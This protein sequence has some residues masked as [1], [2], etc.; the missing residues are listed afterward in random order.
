MNIAYFSPIFW[1]SLKQ[2]PQH[3][4]EELAKLEG[5]SI[6]F[7]EPSIS[8]ITSLIKGTNDFRSKSEKK[9]DSLYI[10]R[11][12]GGF[13]FPKSFENFDFLD[14]NTLYEKKQLRKLLNESDIIILGSPIY[15]KNIRKQNNKKVV[16]DKMDDY[17][18][19]TEN[20]LLKILIRSSEELLFSRAD[21]IICTSEALS[22]KMKT[23]KNVKL[24]RNAAEEN[25]YQ[26]SLKES[27]VSKSIFNNKQNK[28]IFGYVGTVDH[29]FDYSAVKTIL[30]SNPLFNI[31][32]VGSDNIPQSKINDARVIYYSPVPKED[33]GSIINSF[34]YCLYP[35]K[36]DENLD[37]INPVKIYEYL[38]LNKKIIAIHSRET[39]LIRG[40]TLYK[41]IE[42]L[43]EILINL[44]QIKQPFETLEEQKEFTVNNN[45]NNRAKAVQ[46]LLEKLVGCSS[47]G[48]CNDV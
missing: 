29:W 10:F 28:I 5:I 42:E 19:L 2:R 31:V 36:S 38:S 47:G 13:R 30:D 46:L 35:F 25:I 11:P 6:T 23:H 7:I 44:D 3:L 33:I 9:S 16:Y 37:Y 21:L 18:F 22:H 48:T 1:N 14:L 26:M 15:A 43:K 41:N 12:S 45:W 4:A 20:K 32:I 27:E 34:D 40:L 17:E 24:I 8:V 39:E